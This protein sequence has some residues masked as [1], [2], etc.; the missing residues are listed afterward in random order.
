VTDINFAP[1]R[2]KFIRI[3]QSGTAENVPWSVRR[4][5]VYERP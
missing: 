5:R 4:L 3:K 1:V 2:A